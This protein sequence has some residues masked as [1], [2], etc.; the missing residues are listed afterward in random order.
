MF[1]CAEGAVELSPACRVSGE[2]RHREAS[3]IWSLRG[4]KIL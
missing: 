2:S 4:Q 3:G 1:L